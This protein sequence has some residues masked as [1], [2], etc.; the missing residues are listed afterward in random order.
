[1]EQLERDA[2]DPGR[3]VR[4]ADWENPAAGTTPVQRCVNQLGPAERN[5]I[6]QCDGLL[7][8]AYYAWGPAGGWFYCTASSTYWR[9]S[10][11]GEAW[12]TAATITSAG[13]TADDEF[14]FCELVRL[15]LP[16]YLFGPDGQAMTLPPYLMVRMLDGVR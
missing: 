11:A 8:R 10:T 7:W 2:A 16:G 4:F 15:D 12:V 3:D 5:A 6:W 1:M 13:A 14:T 9:E